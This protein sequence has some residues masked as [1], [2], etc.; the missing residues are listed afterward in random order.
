MKIKT[1]NKK[2]QGK[3]R[4]SNNS[5]ERDGWYVL[6]YW[7]VLFLCAKANNTT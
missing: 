3:A 4:Q 6:V 7:S 2:Q 1:N 5:E